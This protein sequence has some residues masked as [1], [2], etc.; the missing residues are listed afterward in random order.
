MKKNIEIYAKQREMHD[1]KGSIG[2]SKKK[3]YNIVLNW[4]ERTMLL[5]KFIEYVVVLIVNVL[6]EKKRLR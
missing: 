6:F 2:Y 1:M 3:K 5:S 4:N